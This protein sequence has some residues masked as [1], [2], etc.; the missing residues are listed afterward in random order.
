MTD[1]TDAVAELRRV[2]GDAKTWDCWDITSSPTPAPLDH[3]IATILNAVLSGDLLTR[4]Q[5]F[6]A[7]GAVLAEAAG[8]A[9]PTKQDFEAGDD[10]WTSSYRAGLIAASQR[11]RAQGFPDSYRIDSGPDGRALTKTEQT[12]MCGNSVCP[13]LAEAL[14]RANAGHL[15]QEQAH[16]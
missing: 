14:A 4:E 11:I 2:S 5:H 7:I 9:L 16:A 8:V 1:L 3:A 10:E 12:R 13:P 15:A 6:A